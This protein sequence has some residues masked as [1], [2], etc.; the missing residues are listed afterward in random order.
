MRIV[1]GT[2]KSTPTP[3]LHVLT[4]IAPPSIRRT[5]NIA[6][7]AWRAA[8]DPNAL[9]H[10]AIT[11]PETRLKSRNPYRNNAHKYIVDD[12]PATRSQRKLRANN[13]ALEIWRTKWQQFDHK[14]KEVRQPSLNLPAGAKFP[15]KNWCKINRLLSG[16][17][18]TAQHLHRWNMRP[19]P[20]CDCGAAIQSTTHIIEECP[21]RKFPSGYNHLAACEDDAVTWLDALDVDI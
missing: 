11:P 17:G 9:L 5:I 3:I 15:R 4:G 18:R 19:S 2:L 13:M 8:S 21:R 20:A 12:V 14:I 16:H 1:S 7:S 6:K 10:N